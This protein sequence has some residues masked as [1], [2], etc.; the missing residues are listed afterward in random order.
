[1]PYSGFIANTLQQTPLIPAPPRTPQPG[2]INY[3]NTKKFSTQL[4]VFSN[5]N[6]TS[7]NPFNPPQGPV[8]KIER[9]LSHA[10]LH[11]K[12]NVHLHFKDHYLL[13]FK[14]CHQRQHYA[15]IPQHLIKINTPITV[16]VNNWILL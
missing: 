1:M 9:L 5:I 4:I 10:N 3:F 12:V 6:K 11:V 15:P 2:F 16:Y 14:V 7:S 13:V 8:S